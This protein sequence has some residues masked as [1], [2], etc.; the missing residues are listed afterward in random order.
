M[1]HLG[2]PVFDSDRRELRLRGELEDNYQEYNNDGGFSDPA[3]PG[4][5][6]DDDTAESF[7]YLIR[8]AFEGQIT[9]NVLG[10]MQIQVGD[11]FGQD[12]EKKGPTLANCSTECPSRRPLRR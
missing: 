2:A 5:E 8:I 12:D 11:L 10:Q 6:I 3:V 9:E 4:G 1:D 7:P